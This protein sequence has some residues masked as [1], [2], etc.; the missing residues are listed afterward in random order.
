MLAEACAVAAYEPPAERLF[1]ALEPL[2]D[3]WAVGASGS[4]CMCPVSRALGL[5]AAAR[6]RRDEAERYFA[7]ALERA[8]EAGASVLAARIETERMP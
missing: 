7:D 2:A 1:D 6:G 4:L 8:N 5:L 3:R